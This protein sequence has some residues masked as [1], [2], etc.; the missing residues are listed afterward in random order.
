MVTAQDIAPLRNASRDESQT[1]E[2][3]A[4]LVRFQQQTGPLYLTAQEFDDILKWKL[5]GQYGR[6]SRRRSENC[7]ELI[8]QITGVALTLQHTNSEYEIELRLK[9]LCALRGVEVPVASAILA[10]TYP[11]RYAVIDFRVWRQVFEEERHSFSVP[12][13][14]RYLQKLQMMAQELSWTIQEVDQAIWE[15][16]L[17][18]NRD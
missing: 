14:K 8:H 11:T 18:Q 9:I 1:R 2:L 17:R 6:Q 3:M 13:Y 7:A 5:R 4:R 12:D 10:L 16:D 15:Y